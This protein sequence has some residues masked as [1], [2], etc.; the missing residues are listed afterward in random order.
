MGEGLQGCTHNGA[1]GAI[2]LPN[3]IFRQLHARRE[4][5][6]QDRVVQVQA[7]VERAS[8][9]E[10]EGLVRGGGAKSVRRC[11]RSGHAVVIT[12]WFRIRLYILMWP[13]AN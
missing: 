10:L 7:Y 12:C 11:Y 6:F 4:P 3:L 9:R 1:A 2:D 8:R 5:V 13:I